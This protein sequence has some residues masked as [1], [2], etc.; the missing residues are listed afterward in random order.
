MVREE[1]VRMRVQELK[2][3]HVI[4]H[5]MAK[6]MQQREASEVLGI[7]PRQV[8]RLIQRVRAE[9]DV[10]LVRRGREKPSN[11][12]HSPAGKAR[13]GIMRRT[14]AILGR[15][16]RRRSWPSTSSDISCLCVS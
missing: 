14:I 10:G 13:S 7:T 8:R 16:W 1:M 5:A 9:G 2:R 15:P 12:R 4:R 6:A 3:V 11:R